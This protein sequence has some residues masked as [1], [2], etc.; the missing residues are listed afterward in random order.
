MHS[1]PFCEGHKVDSEGKKTNA[2]GTWLC[3]NLRTLKNIEINHEKF[4][5]EGKGK[6]SQ[7]KNFQKLCI[8]ATRTAQR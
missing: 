2:R 7:A 3:G 4:Q 6:K 8:Q 5:K 1:C